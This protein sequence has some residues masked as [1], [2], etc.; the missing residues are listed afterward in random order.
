MVVDVVCGIKKARF[1][2]LEAALLYAAKID[3][4][5]IIWIDGEIWAN[6]LEFPNGTFKTMLFR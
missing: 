6:I 5:A 2:S 1:S 4:W 3:R